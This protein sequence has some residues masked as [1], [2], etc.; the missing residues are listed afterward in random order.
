V[1]LIGCSS[2]GKIERIKMDSMKLRAVRALVVWFL[3]QSTAP[4]FAEPL[5]VNYDNNENLKKAMEYDLTMDNNM[6]VKPGGTIDMELYRSYVAKASR[7]RA[8]EYYLAYLK[9]VKEPFQRVRVYAQLSN[10]FTGLVRPEVGPSPIRKDIEKALDYCRKGL[11]EAPEAICF[12]TINM[13]GALTR[14]ADQQENF[15]AKEDYYKWL[16]SIDAKE[17]TD[18]WLP[19]R[20]G[21]DKPSKRVVDD[22]LDLLDTQTKTVASNMIAMAVGLGRVNVVEPGPKGRPQRYDPSYLLDIIQKFPG[23]RAQELAT[24]ELAQLTGIIADGHLEQMSSAAKGNAA[25][26][27]EIEILNDTSVPKEEAKKDE[28]QTP[29]AS[30]ANSNR[31]REGSSALYL[32]LGGILALAIVTL[33]AVKRFK[34]MRKPR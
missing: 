1:N 16:L 8:E 7:E 10:L 19:V 3:I 26:P 15:R 25:A 29:L 32:I 23:T 14:L 27:K 5:I 6:F 22:L 33:V 12:A 34:G 9:E 18:H 4:V 17:I 2:T 30:T 13:R 20:P 21:D 24:T 31:E 11:A 28:I